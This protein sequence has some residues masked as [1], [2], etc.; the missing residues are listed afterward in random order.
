[1]DIAA[2]GLVGGSLLA[3]AGWF[4]RRLVGQIDIAVARLQERQEAEERTRASED[5]NLRGRLE[6]LTDRVKDHDAAHMLAGD[7]LDRP[8][9]QD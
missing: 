7:R 6:S 5:A 9:R 8:H 4:L 2:L 1:M 3:V